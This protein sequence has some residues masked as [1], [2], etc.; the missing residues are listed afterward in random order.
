MKKVFSIFAAF[1]L[2]FSFAA[3]S[4]NTNGEEPSLSAP[5]TGNTCLLYTSDAADD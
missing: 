4:N 3:C 2:L 1:I 5:Q